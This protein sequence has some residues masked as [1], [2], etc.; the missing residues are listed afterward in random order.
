MEAN[1]TAT[2]GTIVLD[3][4]VDIMQRVVGADLIPVEVAPAFMSRVTDL[5]KAACD[6][7]MATTTIQTEVAPVRH[8]RSE[9]LDRMRAAINAAS[10][11]PT[12]A[13]ALPL[14]LQMLAQARD[15]ED[16]TTLSDEEFRAKHPPVPGLN[17]Q[18][19]VEPDGITVLMDGVKKKMIKRY[20]TATYGITFED[21][22]RIFGL[23]DDYP[24]CAPNYAG[25]RREHAIAHGLGKNPKAH[26]RRKKGGDA[27]AQVIGFQPA[28]Q[29]TVA[30]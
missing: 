13:S 10:T 24:S 22:K 4:S 14:A 15:D 18:N 28:P 29:A 20:L 21:Y 1:K 2:V 5:L 27:E 16:K 23:G 17:A 9:R 25:D 26:R 7:F 19:T 11:E 8:S 30:A 6:E 3:A 12:T